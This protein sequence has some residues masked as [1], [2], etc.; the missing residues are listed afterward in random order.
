MA[1]NY[2]KCSSDVA[3]WLKQSASGNQ[4][5]LYVVA[6]AFFLILFLRATATYNIESLFQQYGQFSSGS[7]K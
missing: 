6:V 2:S 5:F 3:E 7:G 4:H 1:T